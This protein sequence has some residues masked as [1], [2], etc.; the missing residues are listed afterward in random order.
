VKQNALYNGGHNMS[1]WFLPTIPE[2]L[3]GKKIA[4]VWPEEKGQS[5]WEKIE[6]YGAPEHF[7]ARDIREGLSIPLERIDYIVLYQGK[8]AICTYRILRYLKA[9]GFPAKKVF[10]ALCGCSR[11]D[12]EIVMKDMGFESLAGVIPVPCQAFHHVICQWVLAHHA[13]PS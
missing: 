6:G 3:V 4:F 12:H 1:D 9:C 10:V 5:D 11:E 7:V 8:S 2:I 13:S